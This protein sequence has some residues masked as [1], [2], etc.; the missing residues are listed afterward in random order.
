MM[1][2]VGEGEQRCL[3]LPPC[4]PSPRGRGGSQETAPDSW[5]TLNRKLQDPKRPLLKATP[6]GRLPREHGTVSFPP[7]RPMLPAFTP[8]HTPPRVPRKGSPTG[9]Q[10]PPLTSFPGRPRGAQAGPAAPVSRRPGPR[11]CLTALKFWPDGAPRPRPSLKA[12]GRFPAA[13]PGE[14]GGSRRKS[15]PRQLRRPSPGL[16]R[17]E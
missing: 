7:P 16:A 5:P 3:A 8:P 12:P 10:L 2:Q 11:G 9:S 17:D 1:G 6:E 15:P 13:G 4:P 14:E